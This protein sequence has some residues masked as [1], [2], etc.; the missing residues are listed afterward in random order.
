MKQ[1][2]IIFIAILLVSC[3]LKEKKREKKWEQR[4]KRVE[5]IMKTYNV[6]YSLR[7]LDYDFSYQFDLV[8]K[9]KV[10]LVDLFFVRDIYTKNDKTFLNIEIN[11]YRLDLLIEDEN[12]LQNLLQKILADKYYYGK[13]EVLIIELD[14]I[15]KIP[16]IIEVYDESYGGETDFIMEVTDSNNFIGSGKV[17][18][19]VEI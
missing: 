14:K 9:E 2:S 3:N 10:Q 11:N 18:N 15:K 1:L 12:I 13:S 4:T 7:D 17:L 16:F 6:K 5:E 19:L 8:L